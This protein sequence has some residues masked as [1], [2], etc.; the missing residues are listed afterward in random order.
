M[1]VNGQKYDSAMPPQEAVLTD[2]QVADV[3]TYVYNA[4]GNKGDA[5]SADQAKAMRNQSHRHMTG[6]RPAPPPENPHP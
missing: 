2:Q 1:V 4:W 3:L 5:F 6:R